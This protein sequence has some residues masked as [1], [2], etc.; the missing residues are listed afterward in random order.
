MKEKK[1]QMNIQSIAILKVK[2]KN[3]AND[4]TILQYYNKIED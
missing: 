3:V 1:R 4:Y 2:I